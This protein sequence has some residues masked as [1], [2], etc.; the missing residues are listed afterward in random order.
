MLLFPV[1]TN[2]SG[3]NFFFRLLVSLA[4]FLTKIGYYPRNVRSV[5]FMLL[6]DD[7]LH[8]KKCFQRQKQTTRP[9]KGWLP[10]VLP[11]MCACLWVKSFV[12]EKTDMVKQAACVKTLSLLF[13]NFKNSRTVVVSYFV[14][15]HVK[16][17]CLI[18][19]LCHPGFLN[20]KKQQK[21]NNVNISLSSMDGSNLYAKKKSLKQSLIWYKGLICLGEYISAEVVCKMSL[22]ILY[23]CVTAYLKPVYCKICGLHQLTLHTWSKLDWPRGKVVRWNKKK[24]KLLITV[25]AIRCVQFLLQLIH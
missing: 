16:M 10:H 6:N 11:F 1:Y 20:S 17:Q 5:A 25:S 15:P 21:N 12:Y 14:L 3:H 2:L 19:L 18:C 9:P 22:V 8:L 7:W 24:K 23:I 4:F 13:I